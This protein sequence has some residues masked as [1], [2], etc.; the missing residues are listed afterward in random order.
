MNTKDEWIN[1]IQRR[2]EIDHVP[3][4]HTRKA[5]QHHSSKMWL[6]G[7]DINEFNNS[8]T[9]GRVAIMRRC[10]RMMIQLSDRHSQRTST[11][12]YGCQCLHA[13]RRYSI[14][15]NWWTRSQSIKKKLMTNKSG[16]PILY[17]KMKL[18]KQYIWSGI[19]CHKHFRRGYFKSTDTTKNCV[20]NKEM[21]V[22]QCTIIWN[23]DGLNH[24]I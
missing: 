24:A 11:R 4:I 18:Y 17:V 9:G 15:T 2:K 13:A 19:C 23:I 6:Y 1:V 3:H 12:W 10:Q 7:K 14:R 22:K 8:I 5:L 21:N 20:A 16:I